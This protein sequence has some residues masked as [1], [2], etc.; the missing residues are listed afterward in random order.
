MKTTSVKK[1]GILVATLVAVILVFSLM[2]VE[3]ATTFGRWRDINPAQYSAD[4]AGTLRGM[5]LYKS[6][7]SASIGSGDGWVVGGDGANGIIAH[8]DGFSWLLLASPDPSAVYYSANFCL[9]PGA[10][11]VG[12]MCSPYTQNGFVA[13][14]W[15]V[16]YDAGKPSPVATY[17]DGSALTEIWDNELSLAGARNLTSVFMVCNSPETGQSGC[18][19]S[20]AG[21]GLTYAVGSGAA[22]VGIIC[23][24]NGDPKAGG[25]WGCTYPTGAVHPTKYNSVYMYVDSSGQLGGFAVGDNGVIAQLKAGG[26]A[27]TQW[28]PGPPAVTFRSVF[29]DQGGSNL[30]AW[31]V[32]DANPTTGQNAIWWYHGGSWAGP[33]SPLAAI[34]QNLENVF[35]V[36]TTEGWA[37][38]SSSVILHSTT[39]GTSNLW[40]AI[41]VNVMP[42]GPGISLIGLSFASSGNGWADGTS[43]V[44]LDT[45]DTNCGNA[46]PSP[47]VCWGGN[48]GI[49][50]TANL[51]S[52]FENNPSDAWAGGWW[53]FASSRPTLIHWDGVKWHTATVTGPPQLGGSFFN[54]T[55]IYMTG[56]SDGWAV[57]GKACATPTPCSVSPLQVPFAL[58]WDGNT[59]SGALASQPTCAGGCSLTSVFMINSGEGWAVGTGTVTGSSFFHYTSSLNQ[60]AFVAGPPTPPFTTFNSIFI[61]NPGSTTGAAGWA[62]G[63]GG[64]VSQLSLSGSTFTWSPPVNIPALGGATPNL[65]SVFFTDSNHGW[66][67][68]AQGTILA[69]T[70]DATWSGGRFQ[71][72]GAPNAALRSV[73][74]DK[75]TTGPG[76]GDGWAVGGASETGSSNVVFAHWDGQSWTAT[77]ISPP[78]PAPGSGGLALN[79][80]YGQQGNTQEG[81]AVGAGPTGVTNPLA[82]VFH[83]DPLNPPT[84]Q[85]TQ[86]PTQLTTTVVV[87]SGISTVPIITTSATSSVALTSS[88]QATTATTASAATTTQVS[89]SISTS[90]STSLMSTTAVVTQTVTTASVVTPMVLP[91]IPGFPWESII[92]GILIGV[93]ILG[94][95]RRNKRKTD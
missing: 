6:G 15:L 73:Y 31:A 11:N 72:V 92:A 26:W 22:G 51:T 43:G 77:T 42:T 69:T 18:S 37:V 81:W 53:D 3:S 10:P 27:D 40:T 46:I 95:V 13:D 33:Y 41:P 70:N 44:I 36:S 30:D 50:Q 68:G 55:S 2:P 8:Y 74:V 89:T 61:N 91:A 76:N 12:P 7:G 25:S 66:I 57:G 5:Y 48:T 83:L 17:W 94:I 21:P 56:S 28:A 45:Q 23:S 65:Y 80:V 85:P 87:T 16:G 71:V 47:N 59:W 24:F 84:Q 1:R 78:I 86:Q 19:G 58:H 63:N 64:V 54:V 38:G 52:V 93:V 29:V 75:S 4:V 14:G 82:G 60:W 67:V 20:F 35:L 88:S 49:T 34:Y 39:L 32:G 62:V 90:I 9:A 79:S